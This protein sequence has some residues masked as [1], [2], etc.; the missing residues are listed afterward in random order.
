MT[1][2]KRIKWKADHHEIPCTSYTSFNKDE[3]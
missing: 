2:T 3:Y 1:F